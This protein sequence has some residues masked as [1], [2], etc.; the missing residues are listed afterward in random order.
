MYFYDFVFIQNNCERRRYRLCSELEEFLA[1]VPFLPSL[2]YLIE[3]AKEKQMNPK[4][5]KAINLTPL[6]KKMDKI[7]IESLEDSIS[8]PKPLI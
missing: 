4:L 3:T 5:L 1:R 2:R 7:E 6:K 8:T